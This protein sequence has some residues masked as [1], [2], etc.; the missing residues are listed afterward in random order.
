MSYFVRGFIRERG[1]KI[2]VEI[3]EEDLDREEARL[4]DKLYSMTISTPYGCVVAL[5]IEMN[6]SN[7]KYLVL[8]L[9]DPLN[10]DDMRILESISRK[11]E[12]IVEHRDK[13]VETYKLSESD[14]DRLNYV[15]GKARECDIMRSIKTDLDKAFE[16]ILSSLS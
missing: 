11:K 6:L 15:I 4:G 12:I 8:T 3:S 7:F 2:A 10:S 13:L 16:W 14:V 5:S 9:L 1:E